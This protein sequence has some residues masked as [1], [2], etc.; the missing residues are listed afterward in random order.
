MTTSFYG[1]K[2][3]IQFHYHPASFHPSKGFSGKHCYMHLKSLLFQI[4]VQLKKPENDD[5]HPL[6]IVANEVVVYSEHLYIDL[7]ES[8]NKVNNYKIWTSQLLH[9]KADLYIV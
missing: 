1:K 5:S 9:L 6:L 3:K 8:M 2:L 4:L 7:D